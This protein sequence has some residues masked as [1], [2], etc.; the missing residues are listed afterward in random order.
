MG[1]ELDWSREWFKGYKAIKL[2]LPFLDLIPRSA[3]SINE[4]DVGNVDSKDYYDIDNAF[5]EDN[6]Q[7][8][9]DNYN[10]EK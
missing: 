2:H 10:K 4:D 8:A 3:C 7:N 6:K 9:G 5:N 1:Y